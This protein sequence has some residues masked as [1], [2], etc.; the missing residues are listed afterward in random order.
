MTGSFSDIPPGTCVL[1]GTNL[2][3]GQSGGSMKTDKAQKS[4]IGHPAVNRAWLVGAGI[5]FPSRRW[6]CA[7]GM[8]GHFLPITPP[9]PGKIVPT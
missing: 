6:C 3:S 1:G 5:L 8:N 2:R 4:E 7:L 9:C